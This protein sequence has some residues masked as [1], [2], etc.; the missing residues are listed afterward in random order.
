M[1]Y[2]DYED[3]FQKYLLLDKKEYINNLALER[4]ITPFQIIPFKEK[5]YQNYLTSINI[6]FGSALEE[7]FHRYLTFKGATFLNRRC[8]PGKDCDQLFTYKGKTILIEQKVRDDHDSSKKV[9]QLE[10]YLF[11][12][13]SLPKNA[14]C[15]C[16]FIDDNF[17]KNYNFY[18]K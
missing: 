6:K 18:N 12:K 16:W 2:K 7:I 13:Q 8:I 3:I 11:K 5:I 4:I 10:N 1:D 14:L 15:C 17:S 9:G